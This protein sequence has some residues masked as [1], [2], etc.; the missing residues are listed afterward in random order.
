MKR[1]VSRSEQRVMIGALSVVMSCSRSGLA[2]P[3]SSE[4]TSGSAADSVKNVPE[5]LEERRVDVADVAGDRVAD[6]I[7]E[8]VGQ[9]Q[10]VAL[11]Q[12]LARAELVVDGLTADARGAWRRRTA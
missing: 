11:G 5:A 3:V 6:G 7:D 1:R 9:P 2:S 12:A 10:R 8:P 4:M